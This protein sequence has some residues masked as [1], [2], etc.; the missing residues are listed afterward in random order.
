MV[1]TRSG[2]VNANG[3]RNQPPVIEQIPVMEATAEPVTMAGVQAMIQAMLDRQMEETRRLLQQNREEATIQIEQPEL[4]EGQTEEG[5]YSGTVGQANPPIV[6]Q[7]HQDGGNDGRGCKYK[8][9]MA[10]KPPSLSGSPTPVEV[11]NWI[12]EMET[13]FESCE[14]SNRQKT[15]LAVPLL[16]SGVLSWWK[17]LADS[18]PK[19]EANKM[20]WED[21]LVQLKMQYCS[22]QDLLEI[23]NEFQNLKKGKMSVIEYAA[24]FTEKMKLVPYLVP[25]ELSKVNKFA[26]GLPADFGPMVK[27]ATTLKAAIW[28]AKNVETQIREKG[29]EKVEVGEKRK[30]EGSS[31]PDNKGKFSKSNLD[32][33]RNEAKWCEKCKKKHFG[34]CD[35]EVTCYKCGRTGHY[36]R[37]CTFEN[38]K[39][40]ECGNDGHISKNC[41]KKNE[42]ARPNA[43]PKPRAFHMILDE[44][45]NHARNQE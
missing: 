17:L 7:N 35:G 40:Y 42:A 25:T 12:S 36:S 32:D 43:P 2:N 6:R 28:A 1:R 45:E 39:C 9:F 31:R 20:S 5:N 21:F 24:S 33:R 41:P 3:N 34:R 13:M 30:S 16:K 38:K 8:D 29:L 15:A 26:H 11:I 27:Q 44:A 14:C 18:M 10:S 22:E 37:D 19:G 4:N 23:N